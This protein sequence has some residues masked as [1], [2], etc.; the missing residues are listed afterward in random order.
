ML[1]EMVT[2]AAGPGGCWPAGSVQ[3]VTPEQA[4]T[5][6]DAGFAVQV[7]EPGSRETAAVDPVAE[8]A[9]APAQSAA[10][11][12]RNRRKTAAKER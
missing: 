8:V 9:D 6:I 1:I 5:L 7:D 4:A 10:P 2:M 11:Q 12:R 3:N